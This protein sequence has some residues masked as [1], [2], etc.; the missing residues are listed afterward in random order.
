MPLAT[1]K[2]FREIKS[3]KIDQPVTVY[4]NDTLGVWSVRQD[5]KVVVQASHLIL[6]DVTFDHNPHMSVITGTIIS[7][8]ENRDI[9][10]AVC[11]GDEGY[12]KYTSLTYNAG[13]GCYVGRD[14]MSVTECDRCDLDTTEDTPILAI[15]NEVWN[16]D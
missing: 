11:G 16:D 15:W 1:K 10:Q 5:N 2:Y 6:K 3:Y 9:E 4:R 8:K 14:G 13:R 7:V 12:C